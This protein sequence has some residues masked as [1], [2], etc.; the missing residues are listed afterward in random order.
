MNEQSSNWPR[1][2][3]ALLLIGWTCFLAYLFA[4][5]EIQIEG[6]AGWATNLPTWRIEKHWLLDLFFGG[7]AMTGYHAWMLPTV[8]AFF[9]L[10]AF[11]SGRWSWRLE[12]RTVACIGIFWIAEDLLWFIC[13]P[14]Y[15]WSKLNPVDVTWHKHWFLGLPT[16]YWTFFFLSAAL[17]TW[18]FWRRRCASPS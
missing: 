17:L 10:P 3:H 9:H 16:D 6:A 7:R 1:W 18:S 14:A 8:A 2:L 13:N 11:T 12:A 4:N 15:G 5:V